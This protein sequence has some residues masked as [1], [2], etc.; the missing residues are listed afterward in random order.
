MT[1][2]QIQCAGSV[3]LKY[4]Q[5][6]IELYC[7]EQ[8][9]RLPRDLNL[10]LFLTRHPNRT[11]S[12]ETLIEEVWGWDYEGSDRAVDLSIKRLRKA[13][14]SWPISEGEIKTVRGLGYQFRAETKY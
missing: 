8:K 12:R 6:H 2:K 5:K 13:L 14:E 7:M 9:W 4:I 3:H 11:F 1:N 10:L